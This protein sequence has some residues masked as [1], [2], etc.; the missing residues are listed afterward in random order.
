MTHSFPKG[1]VVAAGFE[2][3]MSCEPTGEERGADE[4]FGPLA[5]G[6]EPSIT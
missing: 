3:W 6:T 5:D 4:N 2:A 1:R